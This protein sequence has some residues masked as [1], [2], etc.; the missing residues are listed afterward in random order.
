V[1]KY[2]RIKRW[3]AKQIH[4][5]LT[6]TV[7]DYGEGRFQI[8]I[9]LQTF[10]SGNVPC[11]NLP[12]PDRPPLTLGPQLEAFLRKYPF[13]NAPAIA[14]HFLTIVPIIKDILRRKLGMK[15][16]SRHWMPHSLS[17]PQ[18]VARVDA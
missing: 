8:K 7:G 16:F 10:R 17:S 1:I 14:K 13:A 15:K 12:Q 3:G 5:K 11:K 4:Q 9:W 18:Q 2:F 6:V